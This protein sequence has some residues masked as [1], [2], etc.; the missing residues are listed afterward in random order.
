VGGLSWAGLAGVGDAPE[1]SLAPTIPHSSF[2]LFQAMFAVI[3]PALVSGAIVERVRMKAY[4]AFIALWSL[5]VY[6]PVAHWV[7]APGGWLRNLGVLDFAG[8]TVVH[9]NAASA[10]LVA[11]LVLGRRRGLRTPTVLPHNVPF[12][13]LG[14]GLLWFG[15]LGFN[16]GSA[17]AA[18]GLASTAFTNT[19]L[20]PAAAA[21]A[22]GLAELFLHGRMSG[23][24]LASGAVAGMV[25]VTPAAGFVRPVPAIALGALAALAS[26]TAIR[27][28]PRLGI[29]DSLDVFAVHG[30][31]ATIGALLTGALASAAVNPA[32]ADGSLLLVGKQAIGVLATLAFSGGLSFGLLKLV[33]LVTPLR[34]DEQD[35]WGGMDSAEAGERGYIMA[36]ESAFGPHAPGADAKPGTSAAPLAR[37]THPGHGV[38]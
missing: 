11:A 20:A 26:F 34:A 13:I 9:V 7:W 33:G 27:I 24:G 28:R 3:T 31:A 2:M 12:A 18:G 10:A 36:D 15:W 35:E 6:T 21:L 1:A 29:D 32:G 17:L 4:V 19:F 23:V 5:L 8:G 37:P 16:G 14:A 38:A 25:A 30:V 22:W